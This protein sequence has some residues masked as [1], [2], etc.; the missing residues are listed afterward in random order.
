MAHVLGFHVSV[1]D[2]VMDDLG[3]DF[4]MLEG[5][6]SDVVAMDRLHVSGDCR[7]C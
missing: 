1:T 2:L 4:I 3:I 6:M 5:L 7:T